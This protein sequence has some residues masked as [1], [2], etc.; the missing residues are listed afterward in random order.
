MIPWLLMAEFVCR[1]GRSLG[2]LMKDRFVA[3]PS[4]GEMNFKVADATK[5]IENVLI[6]YSADALSR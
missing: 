5:A 6:A 3:F 2:N 1:S 4:S